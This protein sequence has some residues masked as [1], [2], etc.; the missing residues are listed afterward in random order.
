M[1]RLPIAI[2]ATLLL[3]PTALAQVKG[4]ADLPPAL[5]EQHARQS[6]CEPLESLVHGDDWEVHRLS[7]AEWLYMVP[8]FSGAYNFSYMFYVGR[9]GSDFFQR[10]LF[11]DYSET[12]GWTGTDQLVGAFFDP[13]TL[14]LSSFAKGRGLGD[15]G[16][17]GVWV[18]DEFAFRL[19]SFHAKEDC[20]GAGGIE[21]FPQVWP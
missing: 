15:C 5:L 17:A 4:V 11:A 9:D 16:T 7:D 1:L 14:T 21:T 19:V 12:Y 3:A 2:L 20:D 13:D 6:D 10:L 8:C 18:W